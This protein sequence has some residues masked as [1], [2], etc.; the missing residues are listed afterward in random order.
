[1]G[2]AHEHQ[3][4]DRKST[5]TTS[6]KASHANSRPG[7]Q[8][9][10]YECENLKGYEDTLKL[11]KTQRPTLTMEQLV[12]MLCTCDYTRASGVAFASKSYC[13][14][15][16][17]LVAGLTAYDATSIMHYDSYGSA[18]PDCT[19]QAP[20]KCPL[21]YKSGAFIAKNWKPSLWDAAAI[22]LMYPW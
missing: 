20:S 2:L 8:Y 7:D 12:D 5:I 13:F 9:V 3:R 11:A 6:N 10:T 17:N 16:P 22:R 15:G 21:R 18:N 4:Y 14:W 19:P 1:M